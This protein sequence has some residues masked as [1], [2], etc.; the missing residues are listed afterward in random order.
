MSSKKDKVIEQYIGQLEQFNS[1][2]Y[3]EYKK[4]HRLLCAAPANLD[5]D[6]YPFNLLKQLFE[7]YSM[8]VEAFNGPK[9]SKIVIDNDFKIKLPF[10]HMEIELPPLP[11]TIY[12]F[13]LMHPQGVSNSD[14]PKHEK[15]ITEI[16]HNVSKYNDR[17]DQDDTVQEL[18]N[19]RSKW[20]KNLN[21][22]NSLIDSQLREKHE[23]AAFD[24]KIHFHKDLSLHLMYLS[25]KK[26]DLNQYLKG[27]L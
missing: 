16:Y 1:E 6:T 7:C 18:I 15:C 5:E 27:I 4:L 12:I 11:K 8:W 2:L 25:P 13:Y 19:N 10:Y 23:S 17:A 21:K 3:E 24:Y 20:T 22:L 26:I 14:I 9:L